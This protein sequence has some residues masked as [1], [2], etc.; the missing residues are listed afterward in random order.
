MYNV[1]AYC[2]SDPIGYHVCNFT[3][4]ASNAVH[5]KA[6][7]S[8]NRLIRC[9]ST[10]Y[11]RLTLLKHRVPQESKTMTDIC[12]YSSQQKNRKYLGFKLSFDFPWLTHLSV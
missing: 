1:S 2:L 8:L 4:L 11:L 10:V 5:T 3:H 9:V 12:L 6:L 7:S